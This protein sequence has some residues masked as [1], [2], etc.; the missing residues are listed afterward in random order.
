[1][2]TF[3]VD[4]HRLE[5]LLTYCVDFAKQMLQTHGE[6]HPFGATILSDGVFNAVGGYAGE[7]APGAEVF[8]LLR[9]KKSAPRRSPPT[10]ISR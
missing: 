3:S 6:F 7:H 4:P 8:T 1:V 2:P 5:E 10:S 9:E